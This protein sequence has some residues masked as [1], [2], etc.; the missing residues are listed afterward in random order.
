M[1]AYDPKRTYAAAGDRLHR[2]ASPMSLSGGRVLIF[3]QRKPL[4]T[5]VKKQVPKG[6]AAK[7]A[8]HLLEMRRKGSE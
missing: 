2:Q 3:D 6:A 5:A 7:D 8:C 1:S 4:V